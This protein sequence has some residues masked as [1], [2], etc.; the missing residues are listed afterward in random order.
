VRQAGEPLAQQ[1]VDL[2]GAEPVADGLEGSGVGDGGE[3]VVQWGE[4]ESGLGG[5]AL[6]PLV[7]VDAQLG[8]E[9]EVAAELQ[10]ERAE[11]LV[12]AVEVEL[13]DH[14]GGALDPGVGTAVVPASLLGAEQRA[15]LLGPADE[16]HA[17]G[18]GEV[19]QVGVRKVVLAL[20]L[21]KVHPGDGVVAGESVHRLGERLGDRRQGGGGSHRHPQLPVDVADQP[22][23]V[24]QLRDVQVQVHPVDALDLEQRVLTQDIGHGARGLRWDGGR[25]RGQP[26]P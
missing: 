26:L 19:G 22:G 23:R 20:A 7:A 4:G 21:G 14:P 15:L 13:V 5:L 9:R 1:G 16:Q 17:F 24:L 11:V 2:G 25:R 18:A 10:E 6:G 12:Q 8:V 3:G